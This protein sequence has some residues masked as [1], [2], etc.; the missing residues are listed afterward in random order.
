M[1]Q[2]A[3]F[4]AV[5]VID[6]SVA[7]SFLLLHATP[8]PPRRVLDVAVDD[9]VQLLV[10]ESVSALSI[11]EQFNSVAVPEFVPIDFL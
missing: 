7:H 10:G 9:E 5:D 1:L 8:T 11:I 2:M 3:A 4:V 6:R